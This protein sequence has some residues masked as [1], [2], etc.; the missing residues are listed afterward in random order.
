MLAFLSILSEVVL[1]QVKDFEGVH[2]VQNE[3]SGSI[4]FGFK[5]S[6]MAL[7]PQIEGMC[8]QGFLA[9]DQQILIRLQ[10]YLDSILVSLQQQRQLRMHDCYLSA[11]G[12]PFK[13]GPRHVPKKPIGGDTALRKYR[14][15]HGR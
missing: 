10:R 3:K 1:P 2:Y 4:N 14:A 7:F 13:K 5:G 6:A 9:N 11:Y 15:R 8:F 12:I